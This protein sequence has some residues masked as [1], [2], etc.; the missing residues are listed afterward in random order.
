MQNHNSTLA[1]R[2]ARFDIN[3]FIYGRAVTPDEFLG[4]RQELRRLFSQL[5]TSQPTAV[6]GQPHIGKTS[7]LE[8]VQDKSILQANFGGRFDRDLFCFLDAQTL[9][10]VSTQAAFWE[11]A[12]APL[13]DGLQNGQAERLQALAPIYGQAKAN[14]F[15][16]FVLE[17]LF[18]KLNAAGSRLLLFLDEFD[19]FL[20]H[21]VL[22]SGEFYGSLRSLASRSLG[23]VLVIAARRNLQLLNQMTQ[24]INPLSSPYFNVFNEIEIVI[25]PQKD[26]LELLD[27]AGNRFSPQDRNF[28]IKASGG[29][30]Y[31]AQA[32]AAMLWDAYE[33]NPEATT[34]YQ[35]AGLALCHK[36]QSH[37]ADT[38]HLWKPEMHRV[39]TGVALAQI[40]HLMTGHKLLV[41]DLVDNLNDHVSELETLEERGILTKDDEGEW[42]IAQNALLWWLVDELRREMRSHADLKTWLQTQKMGNLLAPQERQQIERALNGGAKPLIEAFAKKLSSSTVK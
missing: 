36:T 37:F 2:S 18:V 34:R 8:Y 26:L 22:N 6:I 33:E 21:H 23:L 38:W 11:L 24:Q 19:Y 3:P 17:Q 41:D 5:S 14:K 10:D 13:M 15:G 20:S 12:L 29:H 1:P 9:R 42:S 7:L 40:M 30:P 28:V 39:I 25:F 4:R 31:L 16:T 35:A 32:A 27:R